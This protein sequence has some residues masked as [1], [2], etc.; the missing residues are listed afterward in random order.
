[1]LDRGR[2]R[3]M[4]EGPGLEYWVAHVAVGPGVHLRLR[5]PGGPALLDR[6]S[7][8]VGRQTVA[9]VGVGMGVDRTVE[10][11]GA[12]VGADTTDPDHL[13]VSELQGLAQLIVRRVHRGPAAVGSPPTCTVVAPTSADRRLLPAPLAAARS[14]LAERLPWLRAGL[15]S[16]F[17]VNRF[18]PV[19][20][21]S[22]P[23][24]LHYALC[25]FSLRPGERLRVHLPPDG[26]HHLSLCVYHR[27]LQG[28]R[29]PRSS[30]G[31]SGPTAGGGPHTWVLDP[32]EVGGRR[33]G[34]MVVRKYGGEAALPECELVAAGR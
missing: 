14:W 32:S 4:L 29:P 28:A 8:Q 11:R 20:R 33:R 27:W 22:H 24:T 13:D 26:E 6:I 30:V 12:G 15:V 9:T 31:W 25:C 17:G 34:V 2:L 3:C 1:M 5:V 10:V 18:C 16:R 7:V 19:G 21:L 23:P